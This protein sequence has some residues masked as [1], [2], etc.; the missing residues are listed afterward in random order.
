MRKF[1]ELPATQA[2]MAEAQ[3]KAGTI[4]KELTPEEAVAFDKEITTP[5][6]LYAPGLKLFR[7]IIDAVDSNETIVLFR[8]DPGKPGSY[9]YKENVVLVAGL[10]DKIAK[11][12]ASGIDGTI[13]KVPY[14]AKAWNEYYKRMHS[15]PLD[16]RRPEAEAEIL[17]LIL[18]PR[19]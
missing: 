2:Q 5:L 7:K 10:F 9:D 14:L 13:K 12:E 4:L 19:E 18:S 15:N 3:V 6:S 11:E 1:L 17:S 16:N 8:K